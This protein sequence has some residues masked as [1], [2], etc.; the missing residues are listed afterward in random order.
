MNFPSISPVNLEH[1]LVAGRVV[2]HEV[3][4]THTV[5]MYLANHP[6][7][8]HAPVSGVVILT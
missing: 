2:P 6:N 8:P 1:G 7:A 3:T 5:R 4:L